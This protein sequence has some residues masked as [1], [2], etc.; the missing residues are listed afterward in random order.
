MKLILL[1]IA[2]C[3]ALLSR[4]QEIYEI[5]KFSRFNSAFNEYNVRPFKNGYLFLSNK[6]ND[7]L[8]EQLNVDTNEPIYHIYYAD[9]SSKSISQIGFAK[10]QDFDIG[11]FDIYKDSVLYL[12]I[13][14]PVD[15]QYVNGIFTSKYNAGIFSNPVPLSINQPSYHIG[16][17]TL[18]YSGDTL[19]YVVK[20][21]DSKESAQLYLLN[22]K[23]KNPTLGQKLASPINSEF[24]Q[25][26]PFIHPSGTLFFCSERDSTGL[27]F[28]SS[29]NYY[30]ANPEV[31]KL[32]IPFNSPSNDLSYYLAPGMNEGYF[33]R[34]EKGNE[35]IYRFQLTRPWFE[36]A[37]P[38][39]RNSYCY[40]LYDD[41]NFDLDTLPLTYEW[42]LEPGIKNRGL[43][44]RH[45]FPGPGLYPIQLNII[46]TLTNDIFFS[47]ANY[48]LEILDIQQPYI[49]CPDTVIINMPF[50]FHG[51]NSYLPNLSIAELHW[52]IDDSVYYK[53][54][55]NT[56]I[57]STSGSHKIVLGLYTTPNA[58]GLR[59]K[60]AVHKNI[61]VTND[62]IPSISENI[63]VSSQRNDIFEY[64]SDT[65]SIGTKIPDETIYRIEILRSK[66][67][68]PASSPQFLPILGKYA[69]FENYIV[70][71]SLYSYSV[72]ELDN[73]KD[74]FPLYKSVEGLGYKNPLVK[75]FLPKAIIDFD[76]KIELEDDQIF[77]AI[78]RT[79]S[80]YFEKNEYQLDM[81]S[82]STLEK[83]RTLLEKYPQLKIQV[84]A[85]TDNSGSPEYNL[86]LSK[87]RA[88]S[89]VDYFVKK[90]IS[91]N[92]LVDVGFGI[93]KPVADNQ[94]EEGKK[95]NRRV[96]FETI[97]RHE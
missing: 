88:K 66:I 1:H 50:T 25:C 80:I 86:Q 40:T 92:R 81:A 27:N 36:N 48:D 49:E 96:E 35:N 43:S 93:T 5:E 28:Y 78:L 60:L 30:S 2:L 55:E 22:L 77:N 41:A 87:K 31:K 7:Y 54:V 45:C 52:F 15:D 51:K 6:K 70:K 32:N 38:Q 46:D 90:G 53:G 21:I 19:I 74:A 82:E 62:S 76:E 58:R 37:P 12:T 11:G 24:V 47:Q 97:N 83:V 89:V 95:L 4:G 20:K 42:T 23:E 29:Q 13:G 26:Y 59:E 64:I 8:N 84:S 91:A 94:T 72:G 69:L 57:F 56:H 34:F 68:I 39:K 18:S 85:Y 44:I 16:Q 75:A 79:G 33:S 71:D 9:T 3:V 73:L 10:K 63:H 65:V 17:P 67:Q 61:V 14:Y